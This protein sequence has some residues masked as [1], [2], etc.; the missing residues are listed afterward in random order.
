MNNPT[1]QR[2]NN[3]L[4]VKAILVA[5]SGLLRSC[6]SSVFKLVCAVISTPAINASRGK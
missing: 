3:K 6:P 4:D 2:V 1:I 5:K